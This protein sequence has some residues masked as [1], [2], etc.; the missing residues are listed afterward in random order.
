MREDARKG[1]YLRVPS[2]IEMSAAPFDGTICLSNGNLQS[3]ICNLQSAICNLQSAICNLQL[4]IGYR[5][6][7]H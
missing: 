5:L 4:A 1:S 2:R 3:A 6:F 7:S